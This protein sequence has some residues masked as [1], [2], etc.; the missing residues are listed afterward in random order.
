M[1]DKGKLKI[2]LKSSNHLGNVKLFVLDVLKFVASNPTDNGQ[3]ITYIMELE[4][5]DEEFFDVS[6]LPNTYYLIDFLYLEQLDSKI[7]EYYI[8]LLREGLADDDFSFSI[9]NTTILIEHGILISNIEHL[10]QKRKQKLEKV[11]SRKS[12]GDILGGMD[13]ASDFGTNDA[14]DFFSIDL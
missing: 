3:Y 14:G 11:E 6:K 8:N 13:D 4:L 12:N 9:N 10:K 5:F 2:F 7:Q 1:V